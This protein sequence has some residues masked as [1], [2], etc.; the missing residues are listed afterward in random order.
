MR[1]KKVPIGEVAKVRSG[2]A[3]KSKD[4]QSSGIPVIKIGNVKSGWLNLEGC[5]FVSEEVAVR[6]KEF[7]LHSGDI[8]IS[9]TGHIGEVAKVRNEGKLLLNQRVGRFSFHDEKIIDR[10]FF[11]YCLQAHDVKQNM[12]AHAYGAAQP[13]ISP[14]LIEQQQ[15]P[16]PPLP[17]QKRI[18]GIL[19]AYDDLIEN[20]QR[21]IKILEEMARSLYRE[22]FVHF[23]YPG[24]ENVPLV[25]SPLG[26]IPQ[27][28]E[29]VP[30]EKLL[31]SMKGGD[32][33]RDQVTDAETV[34][35]KV[36]RGTD[37]KEVGYGGQLRVPE[38]YIKPSSF[39]NRGLKVGDIIIENSVNAK[40]RCIGTTLLVDDHILDRLGRNAIAASFCKV[41]RLGDPQLAALVHLHIRHLRENSR[42]E[43]YQ[44]VAANGIGNFQ[45]KKFAKEE[46]LALPTDKLLLS[47]MNEHINSIF[48]AISVYGAKIAIL[49][50]TRDLLLPKL[51]S[52]EVDVSQWG[53]DDA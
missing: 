38:R 35:V 14:K 4:W 12:V 31:L 27:G 46:H 51:L 49:L 48:K 40:S 50:Q 1:F 7:E 9:M 33:G 3:F 23:R 42:M 53:R 17:I 2:Y 32:W 37:F 43:Y 28:W 36:V 16:F 26:P 15:I 52:G 13:N 8:L 20:N 25:D 21:R 41:F 11:F 44:N 29:V 30:F 47:K 6:A 19:S 34:K 22:W 24:H 39:K 5:S 45:A 10:D 18:A